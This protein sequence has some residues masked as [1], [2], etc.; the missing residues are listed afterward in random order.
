MSKATIE[1]AYINAP[2][3][4]KKQATIKSKDGK[5]FGI[6]ADKIQDYEAGKTYEIEFTSRDWQGKQ[7]HT[8]KSATLV[9]GANGNSGAA[10]AVV[11]DPSKDRGARIERQ[12]AR[13]DA[14]TFLVAKGKSFGV[15]EVFALTDKF[16]ADI[17]ENAGTIN[18]ATLAEE[19]SEAAA[20]PEVEI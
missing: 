4:G 7:Y 8:I 2:G 10:P 13:R 1:V 15:E 16:V 11:N 5:V 3:E 17:I 19:M 18:V 20:Q 14:I 6:W 9:N 12:A